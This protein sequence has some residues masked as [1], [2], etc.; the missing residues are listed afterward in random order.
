[1]YTDAYDRLIARTYDA[2]YATVRDPSGDVAFYRELA[3]ESGGPV[4]ELGCGTGRTLLPIADAGIACV[5]LDGSEEMLAVCREKIRA[6]GT[7]A[8]V[9]VV[10]GDMRRFDLGRRFRLIT[11]PFRAFSHLLTVEDQLACLACVRRHL[12]PDGRFA[13]DVFD[14]HLGVLAQGETPE[15]L[16]VRF[17]YDGHAMERWERTTFDVTR[18]VLRVVMRF[19][20]GPPELTGDVAIELRWFYRFELEHLLARAGFVGGEVYGDFARRPWSA[21]GEIVIVARASG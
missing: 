9:E 1:M 5:G 14:P 15:T 19:V 4:L 20:G 17:A 10:P 8:P 21:G 3:R 18:Q 13:F 12:E 6:A 11:I 7:A 16:G 2:V